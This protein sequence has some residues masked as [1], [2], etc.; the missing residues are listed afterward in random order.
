MRYSDGD[1]ARQQYIKRVLSI[2][3]Q[4]AGFEGASASSL[5]ILCTVGAQYMQ[6]MF[7]QV[8]AYAEHASRTRPNM[9]DVGRA[10]DERRVSVAQLDA[11]YRSESSVLQQPLA[12]AAV[13]QLRRHTSTR[14]SRAADAAHTAGAS[15]VFFDSSAEEL[16]RRLVELRRDR[17]V[18]P[19]SKRPVDV[20]VAHAKTDSVAGPAAQP[21][22]SA[23]PD[24]GSEEDSDFEAPDISSIDRRDAAGAAHTKGAPELKAAEDG[25][26]SL[27]QA[28][29]DGAGR[30]GRPCPPVA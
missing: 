16:L 6:N 25:Q 30:T 27:A 19:R 29:G 14:V 17:E 7:A 22:A 28:T 21:A 3:L 23:A 5:D 18:P 12:A 20:A 13:D 2:L 24:G 1:H 8:H 26:Q 4:T 15:A 11:Y 9:N 10:L